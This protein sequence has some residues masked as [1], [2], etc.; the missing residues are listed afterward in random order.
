MRREDEELLLKGIRL[1]IDDE[2]DW[3]DEEGW[4]EEEEWEDDEEEF[5]L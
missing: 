2:E 1:D 4:E 3:E 5:E